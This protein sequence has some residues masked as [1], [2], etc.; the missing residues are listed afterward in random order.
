[1]RLDNKDCKKAKNEYF[2]HAHNIAAEDIRI[3]PGQEGPIWRFKNPFFDFAIRAQST[4]WFA[5]EDLKHNEIF[6]PQVIF[7]II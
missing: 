4:G 5:L 2:S 7:R 3:A 6:L 1:M